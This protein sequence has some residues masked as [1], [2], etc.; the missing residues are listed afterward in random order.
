MQ[1]LRGELEVVVRDAQPD[2]SA[3]RIAAGAALT[4]PA[5]AGGRRLADGKETSDGEALAE[6]QYLRPAERRQLLLGA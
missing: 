4:A 5:R 1:L 2:G 6:R 3:H